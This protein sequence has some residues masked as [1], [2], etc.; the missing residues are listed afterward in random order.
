VGQISAVHL[1]NNHLLLKYQHHS[2]NWE[3]NDS[4]QLYQTNLKRQPAD[5][6]YRNNT[7]TYS[8]NSN[9]YRAPEWHDINWSQS[10]VLMGC[11][12]AMGSGVDDSD[13]IS[14]RV[15]N[16][17]NLGQSGTSLYAIEYNTI[18]MIDSGIRPLTVKIIMPNLSRLT[19]WG[20]SDWLDLTPHDLFVRGNQL[21]LPVQNCY[22]GWLSIKHNSEQHGYMTA[23]AIQALWQA[24]GVRCDLYQHWA[25]EA[26]QFSQGYQLPEPIDQARDIN[27]N[28]F[29]HPGRLTLKLWADIMYGLNNGCV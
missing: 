26:P 3:T 16:G 24:Q 27:D 28:N 15:L 21:V 9:G 12:Y 13:T 25:P 1:Y 19:Y 6:Y 18:R 29:A 23:R 22:T 17:V 4:E 2:I 20:E 5:W 8:W 11:S 14:A 7:V 10:H